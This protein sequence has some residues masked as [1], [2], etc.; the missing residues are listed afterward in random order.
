[1]PS[2]LSNYIYWA[3]E[4]RVY[5][6]ISWTKTFT[7]GKASPPRI[8]QPRR[9]RR[10][11]LPLPRRAIGLRRVHLL[12]QHL[13]PGSKTWHSSPILYLTHA[14]RTPSTNTSLTGR[15]SSGEC[16]QPSDNPA[17]LDNVG[18]N[19]FDSNYQCWVRSSTWH[20][21]HLSPVR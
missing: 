7:L 10:H 12:P 13:H 15:D 9:R 8:D 19:Q 16:L 3:V 14:S 11:P 4:S 18:C 21:T 5:A 1:L 17:S 6:P 20:P 2:I